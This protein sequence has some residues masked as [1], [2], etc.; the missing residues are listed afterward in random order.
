MMP[1]TFSP[2]PRC[3]V[4][5]TDSIREQ[6][7]AMLARGSS[8][9]QIVRAVAAEGVGELSLDSVRNHAS[10]HFPVQSVAQ[11]TYREIVERRAAENK[12]DFIAGVGTALTPLAYLETMMVK[13]FQ[14]LV[15]DDTE[16]SPEAGLRAAE[17]LQ[18]L[19]ARDFGKEVNKMQVEVSRIQQAVKSVV[20]AEMLAEIVDK[21]E[22]LAGHDADDEDD[23]GPI[24]PGGQDDEDDDDDDDQPVDPGDDGDDDDF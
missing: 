1:K 11:A 7:N 5:R 22:E 10:R 9:A 18:A 16:V 2:E 19:G 15:Q 20:P 21:L 24:D 8:Y 17:K 4:C 6:V 13:G 3:H 14:R 23:D 12:I